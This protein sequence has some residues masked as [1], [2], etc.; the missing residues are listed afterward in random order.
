MPNNAYRLFCG[1]GY[2][3]YNSAMTHP[4]HVIAAVE[5]AHEE[6]RVDVIMRRRIRALFKERV[7]RLYGEFVRRG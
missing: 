2:D 6:R 4:L 7:N 1:G 5:R 3:P